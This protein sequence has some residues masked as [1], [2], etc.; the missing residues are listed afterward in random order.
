MDG[1]TFG[2]QEKRPFPDGDYKNGKVKA[3]RGRMV[4]KL[5]KYE[6]KALFSGLWIALIIL[7]GMTLLISILLSVNGAKLMDTMEFG[8]VI[9]IIILLFILYLSSLVASVIVPISIAGSRY[10]N[11]FFKGEGYLTFSLPVTAEEHILAKHLSGMIAT[12]IGVVG[13]LISVFI[14]ALCGRGFEI[15]ESSQTTLKGFSDVMYGVEIACIALSGFCGAFC[16]MGAFS[17]LSQKFDKRKDFILRLVLFYVVINVMSTLVSILGGSELMLFFYTEAGIHIG[18]IITLVIIW[19]VTL[20]CFWY[21][22]RTLK[23]KLNLK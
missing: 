20:F 13:A 15:I 14:V 7:A 17:C 11:N 23:N 18:S 8:D 12:A 6:L 16:V 19:I 2:E 1:L 22:R 9:G 5:M 4:K 10:Y 3:V 21:E